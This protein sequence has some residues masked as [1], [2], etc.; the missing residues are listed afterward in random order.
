MSRPGGLE[1]VVTGPGGEALGAVAVDSTV[2]GRARGGLRISSRGDVAEV[3]P[4]ARAMTLKYGFLGLPQ[5]GAKGTVRGDPEGPPEG[6]RA[7]LAAFARA[8]APL[9]RSGVYLPDADVG[10][11]NE[12]VRFVLARA[13]VVPKRRE[14]RGERSGEWTAVTALAALAQTAARAG[15]PLRE[16]R[17]AIEGFGAVGSALAGLVAA[18]GARVV[19]VSTSRGAVWNERGLDV[20]RLVAAADAEGAAFVRRIPGERSDPAALLE[21]DVDYLCPCAVGT[22]I[23]SGN[24]EKV[25]ARAIVPGANAPLS[26]EAERTLHDRGVVCVP[27]FL[28]N[29]G[30]VLGGT[31]EFSGVDGEGIR[32]FVRSEVGPRIGRILDRAA[33]RGRPPREVAEPI[34][35]AAHEAVRRAAESSGPGGAVRGLALEAHRRGLL[36]AGLVGR[37]AIPWFRAAIADVP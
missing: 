10:T 33:D 21:L 28:S 3:R 26:P 13:G 36:P 27:D 29:C 12:D 31:M 8:A 6:R 9:L 1:V 7:V 30:G 34:A 17:V 32:E 25:L 37:A 20:A 16:A 22:T 5:G 2:R 23:H 19:A 24:V 14:W 11:R 35:A 18:T 4:L 15:R